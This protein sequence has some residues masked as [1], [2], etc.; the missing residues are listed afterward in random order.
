MEKIAKIIALV[1]IVLVGIFLLF[2]FVFTE[3]ME[4]YSAVSDNT[5]MAYVAF[6]DKYP[7]SKYVESVN[8]RKALLEEPYFEKKHAKNTI[9]SYEEFI[10]AFPADEAQ[11]IDNCFRA[12]PYPPIG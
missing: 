1:V 9:Q 8:E 10:H 12:P 5:V 3:T 4:Y 2:N 6:R 7:D 11:P